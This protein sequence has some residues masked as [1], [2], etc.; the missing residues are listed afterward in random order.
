MER[1]YLTYT[2]WPGDMNNTR[3]CFETALVL[4]YL[5]RRCLVT[6]RD[7]RRECEPEVEAGMFR[8]LHPG[9]YFELETLEG[10]V[11]VMGRDEYDRRVTVAEQADRFDLVFENGTAVFCFPKVPAPGSPE[12]GRLLD[13]GV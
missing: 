6:P 10:I 12:G 4:A 3:M 1:K 7:Y 13:G 5:S 9:V 2:P 8:P 11:P